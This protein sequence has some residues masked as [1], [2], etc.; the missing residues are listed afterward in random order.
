MQ[1]A[2]LYTIKSF[3]AHAPADCHLLIKEH[4][5]DCGFFNWTR[6]VKQAALQFGLE[7]RLHLIDGGDL[8]AIAKDAR[9]LACVNSTSATLALTCGTPVCTLGKAI[10][11]IAGLT[12]QEHLD[13]FWADPQPPE[14]GLYDAFK[15]VLVDRCLVRGGLASESA[16][17]ILV[18]SIMERLGYAA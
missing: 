14:P 18:D 13:T 2:A 6:F 15:S 17:D 4:P 11:S 8:D 5:L 1:S 12:H 7:G 9:G 16:T 10:Y 3:A